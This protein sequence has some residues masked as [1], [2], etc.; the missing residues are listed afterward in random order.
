M[1][2]VY[3]VKENVTKDA[4]LENGY[5][6]IEPEMLGLPEVDEEIIYNIVPQKKNSEPV[7]YAIAMFNAKEWQDYN[8]PDGGEDYFN[9][10]GIEFEDVFSDTQGI[11]KRVVE[12]KRLFNVLKNWRI[13][14]NFTEKEELWL[15]FTILDASFPKTFYAKECLDKYCG[16]E[17][18]RLKELGLIEEF[19][20]NQ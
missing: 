4:F 14:I 2:V 6:N 1:S 15:G 9:L 17:I 20:V 13:E 8:L 11:V 16:K 18:Q 5:Q 19:E 7:K 10:L 3:K 12:N